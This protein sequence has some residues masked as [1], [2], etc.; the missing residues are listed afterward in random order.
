MGETPRRTGIARRARDDARRATGLS[1]ARACP[2]ANRRRTPVA[3]MWRRAP[4]ASPPRDEAP[5]VNVFPMSEA[6]M[7]RAEPTRP[8]PRPASASR[9]RPGTASGGYHAT[10]TSRIA[11]DHPSLDVPRWQTHLTP[12]QQW[13]LHMR[14]RPPRPD[15]SWTENR[16]P[17][18]ALRRQH[19]H[20][21]RQ[22]ALR[23][24]LILPSATPLAPIRLPEND[25][26]PPA[27]A[28]DS[29]KPVA[30]ASAAE[31]DAPPP[32]PFA[33]VFAAAMNADPEPIVP[34]PP[35][36]LVTP[37]LDRLTREVTRPKGSALAE[38]SAV[39]AVWD[40]RSVA[41]AEPADPSSWRSQ[42]QIPLG[43]G[44]APNLLVEADAV[45]RALG[46][47]SVEPTR[48]R[49]RVR[50][51]VS[52][53]NFFNSDDATSSTTTTRPALDETALVDE[54]A[55]TLASRFAPDVATFETARREAEEATRA[56][57]RVL[58][59]G[60]GRGD[61]DDDGDG[62]DEDLIV[63][64]PPRPRWVAEYELAP[65]A[66]TTDAEA[67]AREEDAREAAAA[68]AAAAAE[69]ASYGSDD[70]PPSPMPKFE[71]LP[72][73]FPRK[74]GDRA[75]YE[76]W[77]FLPLAPPPPP[78]AEVLRA[79]FA[80][81][82]GTFAA[83]ATAESR[84][85]D[86]ADVDTGATFVRTADAITAVSG[87][88][89][90][91]LDHL[92]AN[93]KSR[94][95][96]ATRAAFARTVEEEEKLRRA[97]VRIA[98]AHDAAAGDVDATLAFDA[99]VRRGCEEAL[100]DV[101]DSLRWWYGAQLRAAA[102]RIQRHFRGWRGRKHA[103]TR[104]KGLLAGLAYIRNT[105]LF[106]RFGAWRINAA[107]FRR[108]RLITEA[109]DKRRVWARRRKVFESWRN[110][111][112]RAAAFRVGVERL[113][114]AI[115]WRR[116][117]PIFAS[118]RVAARRR[119]RQK[120]VAV[121]LLTSANRRAKSYFFRTWAHVAAGLARARV[122]DT[123]AHARAAEETAWAAE[124][125]A[126]RAAEAWAAAR[127]VADLAAAGQFALAQR[128]ARI[129]HD[130]A[131]AA[132]TSRLA[133][134]EAAKGAGPDLGAEG[135]KAWSRLSRAVE[136]SARAAAAAIAAD[137]AAEFKAA[138]KAFHG[139]IVARRFF[140]AWEEYVAWIVPLRAKSSRAMAMFTNASEKRALFA[141][142]EHAREMKAAREA[143]AMRRY[144]AI[145][146]G[147][148]SKHVRRVRGPAGKADAKTTSRARIDAFSADANADAVSNRGKVAA[149]TVPSH[150]AR[151]AAER[152]AGR[153]REESRR[154]EGVGEKSWV[155]GGVDAWVSS[156]AT[157]G[158][159]VERAR[160]RRRE[161]T[162][163][164]R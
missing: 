143:E 48:P 56:A 104:K 117:A 130:A 123:A 127:R 14:D 103:T 157:N 121:R 39:D 13:E 147:L 25:A 12:M 20:A 107:E 52:T 114:V 16:D 77:D 139:R 149:G 129:A 3:T 161:A 83:A 137:K 57:R 145:H 89:V 151:R 30:S 6:P 79:S 159:V 108:E 50:R 37:F 144:V 146:Q 23:E 64:K 93:L 24:H 54:N 62:S 34:K 51:V 99:A 75:L 131:A 109:A 74:R 154:G 69:A 15:A 47:M 126:S 27:D 21:A 160:E 92:L 72:L 136:E 67:E 153:A 43:A 106:V 44:P 40:G 90:T 96:E 152:R 158:N 26:R 132:E 22:K 29:G 88:V 32:D 112:E 10:P 35:P 119:A 9:S 49:R 135:K 36:R 7:A 18:A 2:R 125:A 55:R 116:A 28:D 58:R 42:V 68:A 120:R 87:E 63:A 134:A 38:L 110:R 94:E 163:R 102:I 80:S 156:A 17:R 4:P 71:D 19:E 66:G 11:P 45:A 155:A 164:P 8:P 100:G 33:A 91:A 61:D 113:A 115:A 124:Q 138:A 97:T 105:T 59:R 140:T 70:D 81:T 142:R 31:R 86:V 41:D 162:R 128:E 65:P 76:D 98:V 111:A 84:G 5:V 1:S 133:A 118:W 46:G 85:L 101:L 95:D 150:S 82:P 78:P 60:R 148:I 122:L 73:H 141:W 53:G